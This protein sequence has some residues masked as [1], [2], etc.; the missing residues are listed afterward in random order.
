ML[1]ET[2]CSAIMF[3]RG[4]MGNPFIFS[5][6]KSLLQTGSWTAPESIAR[7]KTALRHLELLAGDLGEQKACLEMRKQFCAYTKGSMGMPG[8]SGGGALREKI[9][10]AGTIAEYR[11]VLSYYTQ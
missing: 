5:A 1:A 6:A 10:H 9:I 8:L 4:V 7:L 2:G 11:Q 3:A